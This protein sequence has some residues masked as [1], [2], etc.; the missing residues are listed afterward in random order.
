VGFPGTDEPR[1]HGTTFLSVIAA[2]KHLW[3]EHALSGI[4]EQLKPETRRV[5]LQEPLLAVSWNPSWM[6]TDWC[7]SVWNGP[8]RQ[9]E[10]VYATFMDRTIDLGW[11]RVRRVFVSMLTPALLATRAA[12]EWRSEHSHGTVDVILGEHGATA[13]FRDTPFVEVPIMQMGLA[14]CFR[15][16]ASLSR[17]HVVRE[18]HRA[19]P[20]RLI[21]D[22]LWR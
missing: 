8:A 6:L 20:G 10:A 9:R 15:H 7:S 11:S 4:A 22:L 13:T 21:V 2:A 16:L 1:S 5:M 14:E 19:E 17:V 12:K 18:T 3:G